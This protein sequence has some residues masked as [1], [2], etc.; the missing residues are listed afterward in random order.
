VEERYILY[1]AGRASVRVVCFVSGAS[2]PEGISQDGQFNVDRLHVCDTFLSGSVKQCD[3]LYASRRCA[4]RL[5][6]H[7]DYTRAGQ[8][9][10][11]GPHMPCADS[12]SY[13]RCSSP[14]RDCTPLT[15]F[16]ELAS[17]VA[18]QAA[19]QGQADIGEPSESSRSATSMEDM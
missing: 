8:S 16:A 7:S 2:H 11:R 9:G 13:P 5:R 10:H 4:N 17:I 18:S 15:R 19:S 14:H 6:H 3:K 12:K 1:C